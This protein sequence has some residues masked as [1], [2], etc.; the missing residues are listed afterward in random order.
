M[1]V[2]SVS[3]SVQ[4]ARAMSFH[5]IFSIE[6]P[7]VQYAFGPKRGLWFIIPFQLIVMVSLSAA[8]Q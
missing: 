5:T 7:A 4:L 1:H 8:C 6:P 2:D 3:T